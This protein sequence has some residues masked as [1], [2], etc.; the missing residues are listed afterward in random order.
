VAGTLR[1]IAVGVCLV[2]VCACGAA[3]A[4]D[5]PTWRHDAN[6]SAAAPDELPAQLHLQWQLDLPEPRPAW[7]DE[8][9]IRFDASYE[10][11][12]L[13]ET[14]FVSST[15]NDTVTAYETETGAERWRFYT[16]GPVR[17]APT[18]WQGRV[19]FASD[20]GCLYCAQ[21]RDGSLL[22]RFRGAP[23]A[24]RVM[25]NGRLISTWPARGGPVLADGTIYFAAGIWP[26]MGIFV[27]A[28][29]A[30]TGE[31]IWQNEETGSIYMAQGYGRRAPAFSGPSPQGYLVVIGD[32][33]LAPCGR[34]RPACFDRKTGK[35]S[36]YH[37]GHSGGNSH[38]AA[39]G[40]RFFNGGWVFDLAT[41]NLGCSLAP[42]R[43][44]IVWPIVLTD[45]AAYLADSYVLARD[46]DSVEMPATVVDKE[47]N[48]TEWL[49][50]QDRGRR[51]PTPTLWQSSIEAQSVWLKAGR[52]LYASDGG[53]VIAI[54]LPSRE[55]APRVSWEGEVA[56]T[57]GSMIAGDD[58]LF[59][60]TSDGGIYC[61]AGGEGGPTQH[62]ARRLPP[63]GEDEWTQRASAILKATGVSEGYCL[64]LGL[65]TGRLV[66]EL[67]RQASLHVVAIDPDAKK[68]ESIRRKLDEAGLYGTRADV[69]VG[70]PRSFEFPPYLASLVVSEDISTAGYGEGEGLGESLFSVLR[71]YGGVACLEVPEGS[72]AA[73]VAEAGLDGAELSRQE[74]FTLLRR[75]GALP[76]AGEWTHENADCAN[77]LASSDS[78]IRAPFGLLWFGVPGSDALFFDRHTHPP[79][80]QVSAGRMFIEGPDLIHAVDVYTGRPLWQVSLP[81]LGSPFRR[82]GFYPGARII[83]GDCVSVSDGVYVARGDVCQRLDPATGRAVSEFRL[84]P[85]AGSDAAGRSEWAHIA[86]WDDL[87]IAGT[88]LVVPETDFFAGEFRQFPE[89]R[90]VSVAALVEDFE[91]FAPGEEQRGET[92]LDSVI[93]S[94]NRLLGERSLASIIPEDLA[95][96]DRASVLSGGAW[97]QTNEGVPGQK[98]FAEYDVEV[99]ETGDYNFWVR[100][101][102]HHGPF[103]WRFDGGQ[104][105][106]CDSR[107]PLVD[108]VYLRP[109]ICADWKSL[110]KV[111]LAEGGHALHIE[112]LEEPGTG[113]ATAFDCFVLATGQFA[114]TGR[115]KPVAQRGEHLV[116][117]EGEDAAKHNFPATREFAPAYDPAD[118]QRDKTVKAL[119]EK[120]DYYVKDTTEP[121]EGAPK[122]RELNRKLLVASW[123]TLSMYLASTELG[124]DPW[125]GACNAAIV[126]M[127][128]HTGEALWTRE[129]TYGFRHNAIAAGGGKVFCIDRLPDYLVQRM[130][131]SG[132]TLSQR[133]TLL[134][135]DA[136]TGDVIWLLSEEVNGSW[137]T[138]S[139]QYDVLVQGM[140]RY[141]VADQYES[142][143]DLAAY[144]GDD[145][146][147]LWRK[148]VKP[149]QSLMLKGQSLIVDAARLSLQT[150]ESLDRGLYWSTKGC[151]GAI[152]SEHLITFRSS[153]AAYVDLLNYS[154]TTNFGG[155][156]SGC[157]ESLIPADGLLVAPNLAHG[158]SCNYSIY[159]S[160]ALIHNPEAEAWSLCQW[161]GEGPMGVN[162]GAPGA[163]RAEDGTLWLEYPPADFGPKRLVETS[164][165]NPGW[166]RRDSSRVHGE[167]LKWVA[168][169]GARGIESLEVTISSPG[170][171]T[172]RLHFA[173]PD[174]LAP[175]ERVFDVALQGR[176]VLKNFDVVREAGGPM[177][178]VVK[179]F[180]GVRVDDDLS[181]T[182]RRRKGEPVLC[183][184]EAR[185]EAP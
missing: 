67:A 81:G 112:L 51:H 154:G 92:D 158:C 22:W 153:T 138:Y 90:I 20:D 174:D 14:M 94:L 21:A 74:R 7:P 139:E 140:D 151:G 184:V 107:V 96:R 167:G 35:L 54:D 78:L 157:T 99:P 56:G 101:F 144:S 119:A 6:R 106:A 43:P 69:H 148:T 38:V 131:R 10:P 29:D 121:L 37:L 105:R 58:K 118:G 130:T 116:W 2:C 93:G 28:L 172:V 71:P 61:F 149:F 55:R 122:L 166:F 115:L 142:P 137:L 169:S 83:G 15:V 75:A 26:T 53:K 5:W 156:R 185:V 9:R 182:F 39:V 117:W 27:Y 183:G 3:L 113:G 104:W 114:P 47:R 31:V 59:V 170:T 82:Y 134:A 97:L 178:P 80:A 179:N 176:V 48:Y 129:A 12:V 86:V 30:Q 23:S 13:G 147:L 100:K 163:R 111:K 91:G 87:L 50:L 85:E 66:E 73:S 155:A 65:R 32:R 25:G 136:R 36:Y 160:Y 24:E 127:D 98:R 79:R 46:V 159:T 173:E 126:V 63:P 19:Y 33:L 175:G 161:P 4:S 146:A 72:A 57:V 17:F 133:P 62:A 11:V 64:V 95:T 181:V 128:R 110:G 152:A 135:L 141:V 88:S 120:I 150:G 109:K 89:E 68:V 132:V 124:S 8:P 16:D 103:Q 125:Q 41:G 123:P 164:P 102:Y 1:A 77:T 40:D 60:A 171:Y 49:R 70:D 34:S 42:Q 45:E 165:G 180:E 143:P 18:A 108:T 145:G 76:G 52:R 177:R 44:W 84:P 168:A 162:L